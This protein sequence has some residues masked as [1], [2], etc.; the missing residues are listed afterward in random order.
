MGIIKSCNTNT[1]SLQLKACR[2][3]SAS[4]LN[5]TLQLLE[6]KLIWEPSLHLMSKARV[7]I[8]PLLYKKHLI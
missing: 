8:K 2:K 3:F 4:M 7:L 1:L 6:G 5:T